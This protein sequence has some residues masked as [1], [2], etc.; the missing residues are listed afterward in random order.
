MTSLSLGRSDL[1]RRAAFIDG[2][3]VDSPDRIEIVNPADGTIVAEIA[4]FGA[5]AART[6]IAAAAAAQPGWAARTAAERGAILRRWNRLIL[7]HQEDLA[8]ILTAEQ[9]KPLAEARGEIAYAASFLEWFAEEGMRAYGTIIPGHLPDKRISVIRQPVGVVAAITPWNFPAAMIARKM[10]P[11]LAVGCTMVVKPS[12]LTPLSA[13]A[14]AVLAEE[15]GVPPGVFNVV[16]GDAPAIGQVL[17]E[18]ER[19]RKF[20]FTGSSAVGKMLAA[21]CMGTVKR[22]SLELGGN[23]PLIVF[24]DADVDQAVAGTMISKFRNSGQTCVCAN[25]ILVQ[26]GIYDRFAE[27]LA[28]AVTALRADDGMAGET[29]QGPLINAAAV[30]KVAR[31]RDDA[32]ARGAKLL[33]TGVMAGP[34]EGSFHA[35]TLLGD[36]P[37]DAL[38]V[39]EETFGPLAGLIRFRDEQE[40]VGLA[41][42]TRAGLAA[43]VF[44]RDNSRA[45]RMG[46][47]LEFGMVGINTGLVSTAVA[48]F[49][50]MK[51]SGFGRE[52]SFYALDDF[53][54][55]KL[56]MTEVAPA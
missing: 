31:H 24:D 37:S 13:L 8:H 48:P 9:G 44:T 11:A 50:G 49:G 40:A 10:A 54:E 2:R 28:E 21:R 35:A 20:S 30:A 41:N 45:I 3:W 42:A 29:T 51:E 34:A 46:E 56:L 47:R 1:L 19:V 25:R 16:M 22:V 32:I 27:R 18:D 33:A 38:L 15:A 14:L 55:T 4:A 26:D 17:T 5:D 6:A 23:A 39:Q 7:D 36:V 52:G 53:L 12:E 43:Y